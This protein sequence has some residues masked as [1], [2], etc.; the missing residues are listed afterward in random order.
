M[1]LQDGQLLGQLDILAAEAQMARGQ[2]AEATEELRTLQTRVD[3]LQDVVAEE[4]EMSGVARRRG[5]SAERQL[6]DLEREVC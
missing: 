1:Q 3:E 5:E 4:R 2:L 6:A